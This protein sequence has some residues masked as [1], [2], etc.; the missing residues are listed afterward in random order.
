MENNNEPQNNF[1]EVFIGEN[2]KKGVK[3]GN[4]QVIIPALYD[5]I[6]YTYSDFIANR[7]PYVAIKDGKF[8]LLRPDGKGTEITPF[9]Y[10]RIIIPNSE[11]FLN[12][13]LY[14]KDGSEQFGFLSLSGR[15]VTP[16]IVDSF[17]SNGQSIYYR[18]GEHEGL[19]HTAIGVLLEPIYDKIEFVDDDE[20][21]LFTLNG[22]KGYVKAEDQSFIPQNLENTMDPDSWHDLLIEC[23]FD[24]YDDFD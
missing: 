17:T 1:S 19:W 12:H 7:H 23:I 21:I 18:S 14:K 22:E 3:L 11:S 5:E 20:P 8:G 9:V 16:C 24:Q 2:G 6:A 15:E 10:D 4:G 13:F